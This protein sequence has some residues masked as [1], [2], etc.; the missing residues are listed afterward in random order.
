MVEFE[1]LLPFGPEESDWDSNGFRSGSLPS[2]FDRWS[3]PSE[4]Q[5]YPTC[6]SSL[7][8]YSLNVAFK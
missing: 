8:P 5:H 1:Y 3:N 7:R 6:P 2:L 4:R